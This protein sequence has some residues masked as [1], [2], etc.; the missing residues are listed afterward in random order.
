V[1]HLVRGDLL[2]VEEN[3][4]RRLVLTALDV[5]PGRVDQ[6]PYSPLDARHA[7][8]IQPAGE[9]DDVVGSAQLGVQRQLVNLDVAR[10]PPVLASLV[11]GDRVGQQ[12]RQLAAQNRVRRR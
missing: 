3:E 6:H 4:D 9:P 2:R 8:Q 1:A 11:D 12:T 5:A 7:V 10:G